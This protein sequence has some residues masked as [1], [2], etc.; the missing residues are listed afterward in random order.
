MR[1]FSAVRS[2]LLLVSLSMLGA[3]TPFM[4]GDVVTFHEGSLPAGE[5]IRV[6]ALDPEKG[7]SLEFRQYAGQ[8]NDELQNVGYQPVGPQADA[9]LIARLDYAVISGPVNVRLERD[10]GRFAYYH[11]TYGRFRDPF[12]FGVMN[13]WEPDIRSTPS[14]IR[15]L[16]MVIVRNGENAEEEE[17]LFEARVESIGT[18]R[19]LPE[20]MPYLITALFSNFPGESGVTK[21]VTIEMDR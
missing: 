17:R 2:L 20:I 15:S 9:Q 12:Y 1:F 7:Q 18:E 10:S 8:I 21:V 5:T 4:R 16:S 3:C 6:E 19:Q 13:R 11:F 14:Y